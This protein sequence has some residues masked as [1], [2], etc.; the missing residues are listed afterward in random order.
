MDEI[1]EDIVSILSEILG[2]SN[3]AY[4]NTIADPP[5]PGLFINGHG[6]IGLPLSKHDADVIIS[7]SKQSPFGKGA[8]TLVDT[9]VRRSWELNPSEFSLRNPEW[10]RTMK[11]ILSSVYNMLQLSGGLE[12][13]TAELYKLLVYEEGAFFK[14]H[15]DSEKTPGMFGTLVVCLPSS[16]QGGDV[17]LSHNQEKYEFK[18]SLHSDFGMSFAAWYS[19]VLHEVK[20]VISGYRLV[21]TYNMIR[22]NGML[23]QVPPSM[24]GYKDRLLQPLKRYSSHALENKDQLYLAHKLEHMYTQESLRF[25][26]LKGAD[27]ARTQC[28]EQAAKELGFELYLATMERSII[29]DDEGCSPDDETCVL[30]HIVTLS[31]SRID[32]HGEFSLSDNDILNPDKFDKKDYD[33]KESIGYT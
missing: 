1:K 4:G 7:K 16:H 5:N 28:L 8:E 14:P 20:P 6:I 3:F 13:M 29:Q 33:E 12:N 24:S 30:K 25:E 11:S 22:Q 17:V 26:L 19:D 18:T 27:L 2:P 10:T 32:E 31:G 9:S 23:A 15:Q 21:L